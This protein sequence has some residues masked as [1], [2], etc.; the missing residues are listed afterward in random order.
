MVKLSAAVATI[1]RNSIDLKRGGQAI[2]WPRL[3]CAYGSR[4]T[5]V[6]RSVKKYRFISCHLEAVLGGPTI[7]FFLPLCNGCTHIHIH[8]QRQPAQYMRY[9]GCSI[10]LDMRFPS[11]GF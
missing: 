3:V 5:V 7:S 6:A 1:H 8:T 10:P 11:F 9:D 4:P 2:S